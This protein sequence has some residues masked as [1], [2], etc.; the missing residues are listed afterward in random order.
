LKN[1]RIQICPWTVFSATPPGEIV[2]NTAQQSDWQLN[3]DTYF[4]SRFQ[5]FATTQASANV[6]Q[7]G[8]AVRNLTPNSTAYF[9][10]VSLQSS[11]RKAQ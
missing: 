3:D 6:L 4:E 1:S 5:F 11:Q 7:T 8:I 9:T 10:Q 2:L